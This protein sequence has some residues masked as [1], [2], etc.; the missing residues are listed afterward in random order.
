MAEGG[1]PAQGERRIVSIQ[2]SPVSPFDPHG[3]T[4]GVYQ[5]WIRW[6]RGFEIFA[7][8]SGCA[9]DVQKKQ[10]LLHCA[11][12]ET[13]DIFYTF[14][15]MPAEYQA[16]ADA[17]SNYFKPAK[18]LPYNRHLFRQ[19][20]QAED[21]TMA[22]FVTRLRQAARDCDFGENTNDFIR[23]Q[24]IDKCHSE[25]L[26]TKFL[27]EKDLTLEKVLTIAAAKELSV[28]QSA[29]IAG[30]KAFSIKS[31][32]KTAATTTPKC[33]RCGKSGHMSKDCRCTQNVVCYNCD[34]KGHFASQCRQKEKEKKQR[35]PE[36][37]DKKPKFKNKEKKHLRFVEDESESDEYV[38]AMNA[39]DGEVSVTIENHPVRMIVD[40]GASINVLNSS[41][42]AKL[43]KAGITFKSCKRTL[44]PYG[45]PPITASQYTEA[46]VKAGKE[47]VQAEFLVIPGDQPPLLGK[48]TSEALKIL[49]IG[50]NFVQSDVF[51][52]YPGIADGIGLL[53][54]FEVEIHV[55]PEVAP[56]ARK[57]SRIP[58]H[59]RS[60][61]EDE[62]DRL[63]RADVIEKVSSSS[64]TDWVSRVVIVPKKNQDEIRVCVDMRDANKAIKRT[65]HVTPTLEELVSDLSGATVFSKIDLRSGY[66]QLKLKESSRGITTFSTHA[67]LYRYKRLSF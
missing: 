60:K 38:F 44:H 26:R 62:L 53:K 55:D 17:L 46:N 66:H 54:D 35:K 31:H 12:P 24:V 6:L 18:N 11:G 28:K 20:K 58:F 34:K 14:P 19:T 41:T 48:K 59:L 22:Q 61:V 1:A 8:A 64:A 21:E 42:A 27:A 10:L 16:T 56:I 40:S 49:H 29:L 33:G 13:Q 4:A 32:K 9:D 43:Q 51:D 63:E 25:Q 5:R 23:D 15:A 7:D 47:S 30:E 3:D 67:G 2:V 37:T 65:R 57:H 36:E 50:L 52:R 39:S 45:S